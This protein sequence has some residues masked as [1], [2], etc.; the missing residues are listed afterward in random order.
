MR[1]LA[2]EHRPKMII[3]GG[4]AI[5][6]TIDFAAFRAVADEV[7]AVFMV[8]AAHFIGLVAGKAIP[9][10]VPFADVVT[11]TTHKV[12]R[13]PR[14][15]AMVCRAEHA[16]KLDKAVFPMMQGGP[17]MQAVAAKAVNFKECLQPAYQEYARQVVSNSKALAEA[18]AAE[19]MRPVTGG[20]DTHLSLLDLQGIGVSG[21]DAEERCGR[22]G[23]VLNKNAIP[24]DPQPPSVAS[25]IRVGTP[26]ITTQGMGEGDMKEVASLIA[27]AVRDESGSAAAEVRGRRRR[28]RPGAPG[29]PPSPLVR[30]GSTC[31][32]CSSPQRS[33]TCRPLGAG[34]RAAAR[35]DDRGTRPR[36]PRHPHTPAGGAGDVRRHGGG[37]PGRALAAGPAGRVR[38]TPTS[39]RWS[40]P[41]ECLVAVGF[42]DDVWGL[43]ALSKMAGQVVAAGVMVLLGLQLLTLSLPFV[44]A[45]AIGPEGVPVTILL[46]LLT[47]NAIN[48]IDGLD[49]LA[50]GVGAITAL[51]FFAF[52]YALSSGSVTDG[53]AQARISSPTLIAAVLAGACLGFLPHNFNPARIFMGDTG[54]MLIGLVLAASVVSLTGQVNYANLP[55]DASFPVL[56]PLLLP[57]AVLAV[58]MVDLLLAVVR[59][60]RAGRSPFAPD[61][62]HLH[63]RLLEIGHSHTRAVLILYFWTALLAFGA[64]TASLSSGP[65][66]VLAG[67]AGLAVVAL[68]VLNLPRLRAARVDRG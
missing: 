42:V 45:M 6:R 65:L 59:R 49:G 44:G 48:F 4:S 62:A 67:M 58:P 53:V 27:R 26:S 19:G 10:P 14:G 17:L 30:C 46:A 16:A 37:L 64:V 56:L 18:L 36:R 15:G 43:D 61:K 24:Y 40:S 68:I 23:I 25:G 57:V 2:L 35:R 32:S 63:H 3:A 50:A 11:F 33:P 29:V 12:L 52:S 38:P 47:I 34:R 55:A 41:A 60:T 9:S 66:P 54:A 1:D 28:P 5:P 21:R 7:G 31:S 20:T 39:R 13:G 22:A 8:D 51:A